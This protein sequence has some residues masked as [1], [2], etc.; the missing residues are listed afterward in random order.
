MQ[1][2][3]PRAGVLVLL[4]C[5]AG[6][7]AGLAPLIKGGINL[8]PNEAGVQVFRYGEGGYNCTRIPTVVLAGP[9]AAGVLLAVAE[10]RKWVGDECVP[11]THAV[12][13]P[14]RTVPPAGA[15]QPYTDTV[16]KRS[17]VRAPPTALLPPRTLSPQSGTCPLRCALHSMLTCMLHHGPRPTY[18]AA[19]L[20]CLE[21]PACWAGRGQNV[22]R[23]R[24]GRAWGLVPD[25]SLG[26]AAP[27]RGRAVLAVDGRL[28]LAG[29]D[30]GA[31]SAAHSLYDNRFTTLLKIRTGL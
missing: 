25:R 10:G 2:A 27:P 1:R 21:V 12:P 24:G 14:N 3:Q 18:R 9:T 17:T 16:L 13:P 8:D 6:C 30:G 20:D 28:G 4:L 15:D 19:A 29:R 11:W 5:A 31:F 7:A 26:R 23:P 22:G